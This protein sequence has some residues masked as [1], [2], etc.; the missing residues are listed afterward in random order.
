MAAFVF[1][2]L[3]LLSIMVNNMRIILYGVHFMLDFLAGALRFATMGARL[4]HLVE[5]LMVYYCPGE[6]AVPLSVSFPRCWPSR[7]YTPCS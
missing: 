1:A 5:R 4:G 3:C 6:N 2:A 7:E